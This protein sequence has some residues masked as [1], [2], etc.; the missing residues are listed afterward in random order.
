[1]ATVFSADFDTG[2]ASAVL[3]AADSGYTQVTGS[4]TYDNTAWVTGTQSAKFT[5]ASVAWSLKETFSGGAVSHRY[6]RRYFRLSAYTTSASG[7]TLCRIRTSSTTTG[8]LSLNTNGTL[9]MKDGNTTIVAT[10]TNPMPLNSW[11]RVEWEVDANA[12][13]QN[14]NLYYAG[15]LH[16]TTADEAKSGA[17]TGGTFDKIE[18]GAGTSGFTGTLWLDGAVDD[19]AAFPG[20]ASGAN[21]PPTANAG[22]DQFPNINNSVTLDGSASSDPDGS[23][24]G[25]LWSQTAGTA[26]TLSSTT[27]AKPTFT[28]P[29]TTGI[30][31]FSL[32]VTDNAGATSNPDTVDIAPGIPETA[33]FTENF[34]GASAAQGAA[35]TSSNTTFNTISGSPITFDNSQTINGT[36]A[37]KLV[38]DGTAAIIARENLGSTFTN[39]WMR[40]YYRISAY[41]NATSPLV[42]VRT[43]LS[44]NNSATTGNLCVTTTGT[45]QMRDASSTVVATSVTV[46]PLNAWFRLEWAITGTTQT[47]RIFTGTNLHGTTPTETLPASG[48]AAITASTSDRVEYGI[49]NTGWGTAGSPNTLWMDAISDSTTGWVGPATGTNVAPTANAGSPQVTILPGITVTLD[50]SGSA[51]SDGTIAS[52]AWSQTGGTS[53]T[54]SSTS[55]QKPTFISPSVAAGDT[56]TFQLVVTDNQGATSTPATTTVTVL[57]MMDFV[58]KGGV[59]KVAPIT[60]E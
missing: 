58:V 25:Y 19:D 4:P 24:V 30:L 1:M 3:T 20:P 11:F 36:Y 17:Y 46:L 9:S 41:G 35:L 33:A 52:Y 55:A 44:T 31:T 10:T 48:T 43:R 16:G 42:L 49:S 56:L 7:L 23:V 29:G 34:D 53:V 60:L 32:T 38:S 22:P 6:F 45:L 57:P 8:Q 13:H 50:G 12:A 27:V 39:R 15:N 18:D 26:V 54:L 51:D 40:A 28:A 2:T 5:P 59:W 14:L 21:L 37:A 47:A